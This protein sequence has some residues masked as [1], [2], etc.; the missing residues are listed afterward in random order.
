MRTT[1]RQNVGDNSKTG[2]LVT[3]AEKDLQGQQQDRTSRD[4]IGTGRMETKGGQ[5]L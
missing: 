4:N 1:L 2:P 3:T 5:Y